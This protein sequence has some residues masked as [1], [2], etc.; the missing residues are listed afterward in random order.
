MDVLGI[1][2]SGEPLLADLDYFV[3]QAMRHDLVLHM[4][5]TGALLTEKKVDLLLKARLSIRFSIH[6]G[7]AVTYRRIMG[8]DLTDP[9]NVQTG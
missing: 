7:R 6:A 1:H 5:T 2:G 8:G 4:N 3:E 9:V